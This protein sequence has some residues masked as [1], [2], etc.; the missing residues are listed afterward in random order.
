MGRGI[1]AWNPWAGW[2]EVRRVGHQG[3]CHGRR[4]Q[5]LVPAAEDRCLDL[6]SRAHEIDCAVWA[7]RQDETS[8]YSGDF[9]TCCAT[10]SSVFPARVELWVIGRGDENTRTAAAIIEEVF[11]SRVIARESFLM[12]A[13]IGGSFKRSSNF[14]DRHRRPRGKRGKPAP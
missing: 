5:K 10:L 11:Y 6:S 14:L 1:A 9:F 3:T 12:R 4:R 13:R 2:G 8:R 7:V